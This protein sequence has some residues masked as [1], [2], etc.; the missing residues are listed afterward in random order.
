MEKRI[1]KNPKY[2]NV[3]A[4]VDTGAS[5]TKYMAK[6]EEIRKNYKFKKD[7]IFKRMKITTFAQLVVQV[8]RIF[9]YTQMEMPSTPGGGDL[10]SVQGDYEDEAELSQLQDG[11]GGD[12]SPVPSLAVTDGDY[13]RTELD[14]SRSTLL[15]VAR[16]VGELDL[17]AP[18][19]TPSSSEIMTT[20]P[21]LLLDIRD[22]DEY[23]LS[24]I[25]T[26]QSYP[27]ATLSRAV[28]YESKEMLTYKNR[29]GKIIVLYDED[30]RLA[31]DAAT[32]LC[33]RG[34]DNLF[35]LSGG[36]KMASKLFPS[37]LVCGRLP[38]SI[39]GK[40]PPK[41]SPPSSH[42]KPGTFLDDEIDSIEM[43]LDNALQ[44]HSIGSR[45]SKAGSTSRTTSR[46]T[47]ARSVTSSASSSLQGRP[48]FK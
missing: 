11:G 7:E 23:Q 1:P 46:S 18:R 35:M 19:E 37:G 2:T 45:L 40:K 26:A 38:E 12:T 20:C 42:P 48:A 21:Y 36:L 39:T 17:N 4:T 27:K 16:G 31:H 43:Y 32:T 13:G 29:E 22:Q 28:N 3:K 5:V 8:H 10:A 41:S 33:Q 15:S 6:I 30:E 34:Y 44:D 47:T 24:H 25:T 14:S 9:Q